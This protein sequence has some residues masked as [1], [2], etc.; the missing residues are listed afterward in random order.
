[1]LQR[2]LPGSARLRACSAI[3]AIGACAVVLSACG[4]GSG[5]GS[6]AS[7]TATTQNAAFAPLPK[8]G[9]G[10][11]PIPAAQDPDGVLAALPAD[12]RANYAG[13]TVPV[14]AS[15]WQ[16]WKPS[17]A[18][19]YKVAV[20]WSPL[21][22]DFQ[23][24]MLNAIKA[25][26]KADPDVGDVDVRIPPGNFNVGEQIQQINQ[27]LQEQP[28]LLIVQALA[29]DTLPSI[30]DRAAKAG[31]PTI[32]V[33]GTIP[34][35]NSVNVQ[36]ASFRAGAEAA[37]RAMVAIGGKGNVMAMHGI[38]GL[39]TDEEIFR[40][41]D[42]V[43]KQCPD[44]K[45]VGET[46]GLFTTAT[47]KNETLKFLATH[48]QPIAAVLQVGA[49]SPGIMQAFQQAGREMPVVADVGAM[50]GPLGYW[51]ND[52]RDSY[53]LAAQGLGP[54]S[55]GQAAVDVARRMLAGQ[56]IKTTD[57]MYPMAE[58]TPENA[59]QWVEPGWSLSTPGEAEGPKGI[60]APD[61]FLDLLF[62]HPSA[63]Q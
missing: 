18:P 5:G 22:S 1:M 43:L 34:S 36:S 56:G 61:A 44:V 2:A 50:K 42:A 49:M 59:D 7:T 12:A 41:F 53:T 23:I 13:Y 10:S 47:A 8:T 58:I 32:E 30:V 27:M 62:E 24:N 63:P 3:V 16:D 26:L 40:A 57:V 33:Q 54:S 28:D 17:H 46:T 60:F 45:L 51:W 48:P 14:H 9:C 37:A 52:N 25:G 4:A 21:V 29:P 20:A 15:P 39:F 11:A 35:R 6:S 31:I 55:V 19:P 38:Q